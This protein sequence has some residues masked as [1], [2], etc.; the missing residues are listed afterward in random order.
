MR[1]CARRA[2]HAPRWRRQ[3]AGAFSGSGGGPSHRFT[4][5]TSRLLSKINSLKLLPQC[6]LAF[7]SDFLCYLQV[8]G[9]SRGRV[10]QRLKGGRCCHASSLATLFFIPLRPGDPVVGRSGG[11]TAGLRLTLRSGLFNL[12]ERFLNNSGSTLQLWLTVGGRRRPVGESG[13]G[14]GVHTIPG[15]G[16]TQT[17]VHRLDLTQLSGLKFL[18][19]KLFKPNV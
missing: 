7:E 6:G 19:N 1:L 10:R 8:S 2:L 5:G 17:T 16:Q 13:L 3:A 11:G 9:V 18:L 4:F 14:L 12:F 15:N